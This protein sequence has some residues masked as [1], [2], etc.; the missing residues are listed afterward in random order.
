MLGS[1][2]Y[3][4]GMTDPA[5]PG[6]LLDVDGTLVDNTYLHTLAWWRA[7]ADVGEE[8]PMHKL[9]R[10]IG[11]GGDQ[12]VPRLLGQDRADVGE[13]RSVRYREL[14]KEVRALPGAGD[15]LRRLHSCGLRVVLATS[16]S[17]SE[18]DAALEAL[19]AHAAIDA[20]VTGDDADR[21]KPAPDI[22]R[23]ALSKGKVDSDQ[24]MA[25][26]DSVWDIEAATNTGVG[27]LAVQT[28]G[29]SRQELADAGALHVYRDVEQIGQQL[30]TS[31]LSALTR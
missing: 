12:L 25:V 19:D 29:F 27:C 8:L 2:G 3:Y 13:R 22:F 31:P 6:V 30:S 1:P 26:G 14:L 20:V 15:L 9:H 11:M 24:V 5:R 4:I 23:A 28:G 16:S 17:S 7:F 21:T 18:L 10:L